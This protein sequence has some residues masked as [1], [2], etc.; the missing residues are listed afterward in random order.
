MSNIN[1]NYIRNKKKI[2]SIS[3]ENIRYMVYDNLLKHN[4][5]DLYVQ[6][7][8]KYDIAIKF[9]KSYKELKN[10][11]ESE[12]IFSVD[13]DNSKQIY[14]NILKDKYYIHDDF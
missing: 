8:K 4:L 7:F 1:K 14:E 13:I 2:L 11:Y 10:E 3:N 12:S 6:Q 9:A 5:L